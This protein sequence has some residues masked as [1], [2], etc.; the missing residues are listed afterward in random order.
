ME[1]KLK[2]FSD[3]KRTY[4]W[5]KC[6]SAILNNSINCEL[7]ILERTHHD[8]SVI[9]LISKTCLRKNTKLKD[10]S[11]VSIKIEINS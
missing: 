10:G 8:D 2:V 3:G 11:K 6:F 5:V 7:I 4:G 1:L 9:E